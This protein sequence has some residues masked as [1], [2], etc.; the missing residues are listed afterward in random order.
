MGVVKMTIVLE[1]RAQLDRFHKAAKSKRWS[2]NQFVLDTMDRASQLPK[3][4]RDEGQQLDASPQ[5]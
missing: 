1:S 5:R 4:S 2:L 3:E